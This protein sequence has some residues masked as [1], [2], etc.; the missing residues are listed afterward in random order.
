M[1]TARFLLAKGFTLVELLIVIALI[2]VLAVAVLAA[3][4]P[5]EQLNR[6]R[7]TGMESD[8]SQ[9]LASIDRFYAAHEEF[10]WVYQNTDA[11]CDNCQADNDS[12]FGFISADDPAVGICEI[13]GGCDVDGVLLSQLELKSEFRNRSFIDASS[14][15]NKLFIGKEL[16]ASSS[17]YACWV[18][19]SQAQR[20]KAIYL[21]TAGTGDFYTRTEDAE[22]EAAVCPDAKYND[23]SSSCLVCIP[24]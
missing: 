17:V 9:L 4:N 11:G 12:V 18:P 15:K 1:K 6:A 7:D 10:P 14:D 19:T 22:G 5:L 3:I 2:G 23:L 16:G 20:A 21:L 24:Q 13:A 8:A